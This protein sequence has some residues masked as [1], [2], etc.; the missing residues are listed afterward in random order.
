SALEPLSDSPSTLETIGTPAAAS[1]L[2]AT[3]V[4][5]TSD[6]V[7]PETPEEPEDT[8]AQPAELGV[9][10]DA[11]EEHPASIV[12]SETGPDSSGSVSADR[13][14]GLSE[15]TTLLTHPSVVP[16]VTRSLPQDEDA[17]PE[18]EDTSNLAPYEEHIAR[19]IADGDFGTA[20]W[21]AREAEAASVEAGEIGR[22][23]V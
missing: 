14:V 18:D 13:E 4:R 2:P 23:H 3:V 6:E 16:S 5:S 8:P 9:Q 20:Y 22:A 12:T 15:Q 10:L 21:L 1:S 7:S 17:L 19:A 11:V